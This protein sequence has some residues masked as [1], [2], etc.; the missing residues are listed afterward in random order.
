MDDALISGIVTG[1]SAALSMW[2][3]MKVEIKF[4]WREIERAHRR[5]DGTEK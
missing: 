2:A 5:I 4:M 1:I 3:V